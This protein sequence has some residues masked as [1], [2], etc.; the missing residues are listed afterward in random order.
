[1]HSKYCTPNGTAH[2]TP[3]D[4][5]SLNLTIVVKYPASICVGSLEDIMIGYPQKTSKCCA[6]ICQRQ[7][8]DDCLYF[9]V[10]Q[11]LEGTV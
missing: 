5:I 2:S 3:H 8:C 1:M 9:S 10:P 4:K 6:H 7:Q 11:V